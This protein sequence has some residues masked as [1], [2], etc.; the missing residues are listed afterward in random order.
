LKYTT[1]VTDR[2]N[3][4]PRNG[5]VRCYILDDLNYANIIKRSPRKNNERRKF[6]WY[7][8]GSLIM[9][10]QWQREGPQPLTT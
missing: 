8:Y 10:I 4:F 1:H 9:R 2:V 7:Y 5:I 3:C 6:I